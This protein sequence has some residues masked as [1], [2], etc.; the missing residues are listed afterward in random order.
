MTIPDWV[1][2][3]SVAEWTIL[4]MLIGTVIGV[5]KPHILDRLF[6]GPSE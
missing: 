5:L 1:Y 6:G 2:W 4:G 3:L